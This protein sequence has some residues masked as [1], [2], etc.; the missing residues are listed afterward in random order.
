MEGV[1][2]GASTAGEEEGVFVVAVSL[3]H[4]HEE[5]VARHSLPFLPCTVRVEQL[6]TDRE[7]EREMENFHV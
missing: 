2:T 3:G 4:S 7:R 1:Q 6:E 5:D